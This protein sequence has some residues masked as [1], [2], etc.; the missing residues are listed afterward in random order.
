VGVGASPRG[1]T[2]PAGSSTGR[3]A[4]SERGAHS[5]ARR[6][7]GGGAAALTSGPAAGAR[8]ASLP[9]RSAPT[10]RRRR[11]MNQRK[12]A[13]ATRHS[14]TC[15]PLAFAHPQVAEHCA[16]VSRIECN[17][18]APGGPGMVR[19]RSMALFIVASS[20]LTM[21]GAGCASATSGPGGSSESTSTPDAST[22]DASAGKPVLTL[23]GGSR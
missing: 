21:A 13:G 6:R 7:V 20:L 11:R 4:R 15:T 18:L 22:S 2:R 9:S 17:A 23:K 3:N 16:V 19:L 14:A 10:R 8:A 1:R 12:L 5:R